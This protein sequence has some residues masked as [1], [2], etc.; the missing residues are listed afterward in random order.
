MMLHL[1]LGA[2]REVLGRVSM[3]EHVAAAL[4]PAA[5]PASRNLDRAV[6][7]PIRAPGIFYEPV[8]ASASVL[9]LEYQQQHCGSGAAAAAVEAA[10]AAVAAANG[11]HPM[12]GQA[13]QTFDH[14]SYVGRRVNGSH[15]YGPFSSS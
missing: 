3:H 13:C 5:V 15:Q 8:A 7:L 11:V 9:S 10:A 14:H 2:R 1:E 6:A 4:E 12:T